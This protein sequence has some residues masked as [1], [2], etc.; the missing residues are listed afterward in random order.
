MNLR[1]VG[2]KAESGSLV[3]TVSWLIGVMPCGRGRTSQG[4]AICRGGRWGDARVFQVLK[5]VGGF[6]GLRVDLVN[7]RS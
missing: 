3:S 7:D 2:C 5:L 1:S 4:L 6:R